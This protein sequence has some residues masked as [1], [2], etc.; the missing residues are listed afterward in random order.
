[1]CLPD[2]GRTSNYN[3]QALFIVFVMVLIK[4]KLINSPSIF[5]PFNL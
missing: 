2:F 3:Y 4:S 5:T 1:M